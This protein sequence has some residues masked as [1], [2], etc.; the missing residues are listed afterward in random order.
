M[1][2]ASIN[3]IGM[4]L[5]AG[6]ALASH[7]SGSVFYG[8]N[9][10]GT[11]SRFDM[12]A[13]TVT[14]L[15]AIHAG[16]TT[17]GGFQDLEFDGAGNLYALRADSDSSTFPPAS[18]NQ[19]YRITNPTLGT[20]IAAGNIGG[21]GN[22]Y[23]ALGYSAATSNFYSVNGANGYL[24]TMDVTTGAFGPVSSVPNGFRF[25]ITALAMNPVT[26]LA[27]GIINAGSP[28]PFGSLDYSLIS[29][30]LT[31]GLS[32]VI[33]SFGV[34]QDQFNSLRFDDAGVAY[35]VDV[36][37]GNVYTVSTSTGAASF[38][39]AGGA[40]AMNTNGLAFIPVPAPAGVCVFGA[41]AMATLRRR[42]HV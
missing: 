11:L 1:C 20:A 22:P 19:F 27:Y 36:N 10:A 6:L 7:A 15:A 13:Q 16:P 42:R 2:K 31:T 39:F 21:G 41:A 9:T 30:N 14:P 38:L 12:T 8:V 34:G 40:A 5:F 24:G 29:M 28:P 17:P 23:G 37:N 35:T 33:G 32:T 3:G 4:F 25:T 18:V 26:G